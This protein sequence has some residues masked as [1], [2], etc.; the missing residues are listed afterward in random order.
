M[1]VNDIPG[2]ARLEAV[3]AELKRRPE[4]ARTSDEGERLK[5]KTD[6]LARV[7]AQGNANLARPPLSA[8]GSKKLVVETIR[9]CRLQV[10]TAD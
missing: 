3:E 8:F 10:P 1:L 4:A 6:A 7:I 9:P 5:A 2:P